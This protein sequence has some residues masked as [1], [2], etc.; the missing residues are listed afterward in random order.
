[1]CV[2]PDDP[3]STA[4]PASE[5]TIWLSG[6][7]VTLFN[8]L[9]FP[10]LWMGGLI[11]ILGWALLTT[12][13]LH[14]APGF[15]WLAALIVAVTL[16]MLWFVSR[17]QLVGYAGRE[18]VVA[19]YWRQARIPFTSVASVEPVWWYPRRLVR[20]RFNTPTPFGW[21]VYYLPKWGPFRLL[22]T[23]PDEELRRIIF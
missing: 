11:G 4:G 17:L 2:N 1:M 5:P 22:M 20:I 15:R 8:K 3:T 16:W 18:L 19:N 6:K 10:P 9:L 12:G 23:A 14:I 13:G 7:L 21:T